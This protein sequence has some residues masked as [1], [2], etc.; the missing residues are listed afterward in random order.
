MAKRFEIPGKGLGDVPF[1]ADIYDAH[2]GGSSPSVLDGSEQYIVVDRGQRGDD[3]T[4]PIF[5]SEARIYVRDDADLSPLFKREDR[6]VRIEIIRTDTGNL[7]FE[8]F[9]LTEF[10]EDAPYL[11]GDPKIQIRAADGVSTLKQRGFDYFYGDSY[12]YVPYTT[13][14]IDF[15][16][17]LYPD[18][19]NLDIE[20]GMEW[21]PDNSDLGSGD[22]PLRHMGI[23][24]DNYKEDRK[25]GNSEWWNAFAVLKDMLKDFDLTLRQVQPEGEWAHW[26]IRH[27]SALDEDSDPAG[28][29]VWRYNPDATL[30]SGYPKVRTVER[31]VTG[32]KF[33]V[34][35]NR[36]LDRRWQSFSLKHDHT[37]VKGLVGE[38]S[39]ENIPLGSVSDPWTE[40]SFSSDITAEVV[41]YS[42]DNVTPDQTQDNQRLFRV[43][44]DPENFSGD[45]N[46]EYLIEQDLGNLSGFV[47]QA[48]G[49]ITTTGGVFSRVNMD[50]PTGW[51]EDRLARLIVN[52]D[53]KWFLNYRRTNVRQSVN[54]GTGTVPVDPIDGPIPKGAVVPFVRKD[55]YHNPN[56]NNVSEDWISYAKSTIKLTERAEKGDETLVGE[57]SADVKGEW[58][59]AYPVFDTTKR[60]GVMIR[61]HR[62]RDAG[63]G[64]QDIVFP[65][66]DVNGN[67]VQGDV[68]L[69]LGVR[70]N[71]EESPNDA[72]RVNYLAHCF[73]DVDV[74]I[75]V[76]GEPL[77][78]TITVASVSE[79]GE[80]IGYEVRTSDTPTPGNLA[81]LRGDKNGSYLPE[82]FGIGPISGRSNSLA[83]GKLIGREKM[84]YMREDPERL[85]LTFPV[86]NGDPYIDA[87]ELL[88]FDGRYWT[89]SNIR[90]VIQ[91][92]EIE[93]EIL[94][95]TDHGI[96]GIIYTVTVQEKGEERSGGGGGGVGGS[97]AGF[98]GNPPPA[99]VLDALHVEDETFLYVASGAGENPD[100][101]SVRAKDEDDMASDSDVHLPT[102]QSVKAYVDD[103]LVEADLGDDGTTDM[104][105]IRQISTS[106]DQNSIFSAGDESKELA[107]DVAKKWPN[108]D[109]LDGYEGSEVAVRAE[110]ESI[111]GSWTFGSP[112]K[113]GD[114]LQ[115]PQ[116][117]DKQTNWAVTPDGSADF[118]RV[119]TDELV[120]KT[121][122]TDLTQAL[123]GSDYLTKSVATLAQKFTIPFGD[124]DPFNGDLSK[125]STNADASIA[126]V[127]EKMEVTQGAD[128]ADG[129]ATFYRSVPSARVTITL[130]VSADSDGT[131]SISGQ[132]IDIG[133]TYCRRHGSDF[134]I[135][136]SVADNQP[137]WSPNWRFEIDFQG[138]ADWYVGG[139]LVESG[140]SVFGSSHDVAFRTETASG[141]TFYVDN[142][143]VSEHQT[144]TVNDLPGQKD[145]R[146]F[147]VDDWI[148]LRVVDNSGGGLVIKDVWGQ[149]ESYND[150]LNNTQNWNFKCRDDGGQSGTD[151][152][153][154]APALDYG[155]SGQGLIRRTV[156]G[157]DAPYSAIETWTGNPV[158]NANYSTKVM[159]GNLSGAPTLS[160]GTTPS[161]YGFYA[162]G[163]AYLEGEI[164]AASGQ[165][166][167]WSIITGAIR[168]S[169]GDRQVIFLGD[170]AFD[171]AWGGTPSNIPGL[172]MR[173]DDAGDPSTRAFVHVG[174]TYSNGMTG[175]IGFSLTH[176]KNSDAVFEVAV[177]KDDPSNLTSYL[178]HMTIGGSVDILPAMEEQ[179]PVRTR[180]VEYY[181]Q[182]AFDADDNNRV[183]DSRGSGNYC[184]LLG[185][186]DISAGR[187][188]SG[189]RFA[190]TNDRAAIDHFHNFSDSGDHFSVACW[191]Y[192]LEEELC[193][194]GYDRNEYWRLYVGDNVP[195]GNLG[196]SISD[197][198]G[199]DDIDSGVGLPTDTWTHIAVVY[200]AGTLEFWIDGEKRSTKSTKNSWGTGTKRYG[201]LAE[202]S[203]A[204]NFDGSRNSIQSNFYLDQFSYF[205]KSLGGENIRSLYLWP[206]SEKG[207]Y[208]NG[209][210]IDTD[211]LFARRFEMKSGGEI[212]NAG[213]DFTLDDSGLELTATYGFS[214]PNAITFDHNG[215][216]V[217]KFYADTQYGQTIL[218]GDNGQ[219]LRLEGA[220]E[221]ISEESF[222]VNDGGSSRLYLDNDWLNEGVGAMRFTAKRSSS[223][224]KSDLFNGN[225]VLY[226]VNN[227]GDVEIWAA[228]RNSDDGTFNQSKLAG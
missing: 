48:N 64:T 85:T 188:G 106:G 35:H 93:V 107:I 219:D 129:R 51:A 159:T 17:D 215:D 186:A 2:Y 39:F 141:E 26:H 33:F 21:Y 179:V 134:E 224:S 183:A 163:N 120:A 228:T 72:P 203:E 23:K 74:E 165:I 101:L 61:Q 208:I 67:I 14:I 109:K 56:D 102:Q 118:R 123:A 144:L 50:P 103:H 20:F 135:N 24:P 9:M 100:Y 60:N 207:T 156:E 65:L 12:T 114:R 216:T 69:Q 147:V 195:S 36:G 151:I 222:R 42:D 43:K 132:G 38:G 73:D 158:D 121:F 11:P 197:P 184:E 172:Y 220:G 213:D 30:K 57:I 88:L 214:E 199:T 95:Y 62:P 145:A 211:T 191:V 19:K 226:A 177:D 205:S 47:G 202:D 13:G 44:Y 217:G 143:Q 77:E 196:F 111:P 96:S 127:N 28:L 18:S 168:D 16:K 193:I 10:F 149:V 45:F 190:D 225:A 170:D 55:S 126:I 86:E 155:Q 3:D 182:Y 63:W 25:E 218:K 128:Q 8:G 22:N 31:D 131:G 80:G 70:I 139:N 54:K 87:H 204:Q 212:T 206:S 178:D 119:F 148:R 41:E 59:V 110:D 82:N 94:E 105:P 153:E 78:E 66:E 115:H 185:G 125:W 98:G 58:K 187:V 49:K 169:D 150:N 124:R 92:G 209:G 166:A 89:I 76:R 174:E 157:A 146:V 210:L 52:G 15:L 29:K 83:L 91:S 5:P 227:G 108:A 84:R 181:Y 164:V 81:R 68:T 113:F 189:A 1:R 116:H 221:V 7:T 154:E 192:L 53:K 173:E 79:F 133:S 201:F 198:N 27:R 137:A 167:N 130:E 6:D 176:G 223:V 140:F 37:P 194:A 136:G 40:L 162:S 75:T 46:F 180:D 160:N 90:H 161:G 112:T 152:N 122:T 99:E 175:R 142:F 34:D 32:K 97:V 200:K 138:N 117:T 71:D 171:G 4:N 104:D